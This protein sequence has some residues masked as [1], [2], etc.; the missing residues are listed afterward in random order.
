MLSRPASGLFLDPGLGKTAIVLHSFKILKPKKIVTKL[1]VVA[2]LRIVYNVWPKEIN[3]WGLGF[4]VGI[5]HG[6]DKGKVLLEDHDVYLINYESLEWL[7]GNIQ[8]SYGNKAQSN[9]IVFDESSKIKNTRTAR[10]KIVKK[11]LM[12]KDRHKQLIFKRRSILTGSPIPN[13]LRDIFGQVFALDLGEAFGSYITK[14]LVEYFYPSGYMGYEWLPF[15]DSEERIYKKLMPLVL[16]LGHDKLD[17]PPLHFIDRVVEL[18]AEARRVYDQIEKDFILELDNKPSAITSASSASMKL[19]QMTGGCLY[20]AEKGSYHILHEEKI[21]ELREIV[22]ELQGSPCL[23]AY[24]F[25][26]ELDLLLKCFPKT[27]YIG[28]GVSP[29][30]GKAIED[31]WN[32]GTIPLLFGHP[33]SIAHGLNLQGAGYN[34]VFFSLTWNLENYEQFICRV[35]RQGQK[36]SVT[37]HRIIAKDTIDEA[38]LIALNMKDKRQQNMLKALEQYYKK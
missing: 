24:E 25:N 30:E 19:R 17:L 10:F 28:G 32:T 14:F 31:K 35:W 11:L 18:P 22:E 13:S 4:S 5:L 3:K 12:L 8:L 21:E 6:K 36:N 20:G 38:I 29:K 1:F 9:W 2:K 7:L 27:P 34:V 33:E 15:K 23:V 26:H 16:R 37:V